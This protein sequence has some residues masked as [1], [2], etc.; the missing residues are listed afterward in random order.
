MVLAGPAPRT[1]YQPAPP[2]FAP[3][4]YFGLTSGEQAT[5]N[6]LASV[7]VPLLGTPTAT[8]TPSP[9]TST[10]LMA[11]LS[12]QTGGAIGTDNDP[13]QW[14]PEEAA[15][16]TDRALARIGTANPELAQSIAESRGKSAAEG[17]DVP[18]YKDVLKGVGDVLHA[19]HLD[20]VFELMGRTAQIVPE[21]VHDFGKQDVW[22]N[23][24]DALAGHSRISWDDVLVDNFGMKRGWLTSAIGFVGDVATDPLTYLTFGTGGLGREA[25]S[26]VVA[27]AGIEAAIKSGVVKTAEGGIRDLGPML[28]AVRAAMPGATDTELARA[29]FGLTEPGAKLAEA[30][31]SGM[32]ARVRSALH[33]VH[34]DAQPG[35]LAD[36][37]S[38]LERQGLQDVTRLGDQMFRQ[39]STGGWNRA[40]AKFAKE[41]GVDKS[42]V[43][44]ILKGYVAQGNSV[45]AGMT[46]KLAYERGK[47]AAAALGGIRFRMNIP[48]LQLRVSGARI[49]PWTSRMDF[50]MGRRFF[51]GLSGEVRLAKMVGEGE[52]PLE[53]LNAFW[54]KGWSGLRTEYRATYDKMGGH[55]SSALYTLSEGIGG[56]T[57]H[58]SPHH[59]ILRGG[60][61]PARYASQVSIQARHVA[62]QA[63]DEI[64]TTVVGDKVL[65]PKDTSER[66]VHASQ[67][68]GEYGQSGEFSDMLNEYAS[69]TPTPGTSAAVDYEARIQQLNLQ[70]RNAGEEGSPAHLAALDA[71]RKDR[72]RAVEL[73]QQIAKLSGDGDV[74]DIFRQVNHNT[75]AARLRVGQNPDVYADDIRL[76]DDLQPEDAVANSDGRAWAVDGLD[77]QA[78]INSALTDS[79][80]PGLPVRGV[81]GTLAGDVAGP[82]AVGGKVAAAEVDGV[83]RAL[84][85][86][87]VAGQKLDP[88]SLAGRLDGARL[89]GRHDYT[90]DELTKGMTPEERAQV[91]DTLNRQRAETAGALDMGTEAEAGVRQDPTAIL[92]E[93]TDSELQRSME[94]KVGI[95]SQDEVASVVQP[96]VVAAGPQR[97]LRI[98]RTA[99]VAGTPRAADE[100]IDPVAAIHDAYKPILDDIAA[101]G[102]GAA[103]AGKEALTEDQNAIL[104]EILSTTEGRDAQ[105]AAITTKL[106]KDQGYT[107]LEVKWT[108]DAGE[109]VTS[110]VSFFDDKVEAVPMSR[111]NPRAARLSN[112]GSQLR[113]VTSDLESAVGNKPHLIDEIMRRTATMPREDAEKLAQRILG[114]AGIRLK[115][116]QSVFEQ[117]AARLMELSTKR[118]AKHVA[119]YHTGKAIR[120]AENLGL[121]RGG[122]GAHAVGYDKYR[123]IVHEAGRAKLSQLSAE[124]QAASEKA[125]KF[126]AANAAELDAVAKSMGD[127]LHEAERALEAVR[128]EVNDPDLTSALQTQLTELDRTINDLAEQRIRAAGNNDRYFTTA[129]D[130]TEVEL[131]SADAAEELLMGRRL[132]KFSADVNHG[133]EQRGLPEAE[134]TGVGKH[135]WTDMG[136]GVWRKREPSSTDFE[137]LPGLGPT[138]YYYTVKD[139]TGKLRVLG[140]R[141][142]A[143]VTPDLPGEPASSLRAYVEYAYVHP[144]LRGQGV[145]TTLTMKHWGDYGVLD[146]SPRQ[147]LENMKE[148]V[149]A[150]DLSEAGAKGAKRYT[151]AA[152][153]QSKQR[154][155]K[156][157]AERVTKMKKLAEEAE[158][159][160]RYASLQ[161]IE[162]QNELNSLHARITSPRAE[163]KQALFQLEAVGDNANMAGMVPVQVPGFQ[164]YAMPAFMAQEFQRAMH[165]YPKL[166]GAHAA[167]RQF[168]SWWKTMATWLMPGFH[169]RNLEGAFFNNWLGGVDLRSYV[170]AS[171]IR[172]AEREVASGKAGKWA[173]RAIGEKDGDLVQAL[174][175][176]EPS[177]YLMGK[178]IEELTYFDLAHLGAGLNLT[179][180]NGRLF[181]EAQLTVEAEIKRFSKKANY[182]ELVERGTKPYTKAMRGAGTMTENIMR[183]AS[184][185]AEMRKGKSVWESRAMTMMRHGDYEDLTDF[186]YTW[187]RDLIPFY[188]W[189][190]TNTPFQVHQLLENPAKL[191]AVQ[192]AQR[193]VYGAQGLD[194]EKEQHRMPGWMGETGGFTIPFGVKEDQGQL[195]YDT[196]MLDL[197][198]SD[199]F[200]SGREFV[201]SFLP[202]VRPFLE[203]Y[204]FHQQTFSG[205][206]LEGKKMLMNPLFK[207]IAPFLDAMGLVERGPDGSQYMSDQT[208]NLLGIIPIYSRFKN[209]I[210]EDPKSVAK[211]SN[212]VASAVFGLGMRPIDRDALAANELNFY[213][214]QVLPQVEHL[215]QMGYPLPT[216][217]DLSATVGTTDSILQKLGITPGP[218]ES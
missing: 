27:E 53:A 79:A 116:G 125:A 6:T 128:A 112:R 86:G 52:A 217:D 181:A 175:V 44:G 78:P 22:T 51:A 15:A 23:V 88:S 134:R 214:D 201:S 212:M 202:T 141:K 174:K 102:E 167:F 152:L 7:G 132:D 98:D 151:K 162:A 177:G 114:D 50:S 154:V 169:V 10:P 56:A 20:Q 130:G 68:A 106:L 85:P 82:G 90:L 200:M 180:S 65:L 76:V 156:E 138:T 30:G 100:V 28:E 109:E 193:A 142:I 205:A 38:T 18:W 89:D 25:A 37:A 160:H 47:E 185:V 215:Q 104:S 166:D 199:M 111:I 91:W 49:I 182:L 121:L 120:S 8:G 148:A 126:D 43:D 137:E 83:I 19:T 57:K 9:N 211:R 140:Y 122:Y 73:E 32:L 189:M 80:I 195:T 179:A 178:P 173:K 145:G 60:G 99:K 206:P 48:I 196:V 14:T 95:L 16:Q 75:S 172:F 110:L 13:S 161:H 81:V 213:Y 101:G 84:E 164:Q 67:N 204:I 17:E 12:R 187:V 87:R 35:V 55:G 210:Y 186:E 41:L 194:Y 153:E 92:N 117:D 188:K 54:E 42:T 34:P 66:I 144:A 183:T 40:S 61:L 11:W 171:R 123:V 155:S 94:T 150:N 184:F 24:A 191:L 118:T 216:T 203:S 157:A 108:N 158:R 165:G 208:N 1:L 105:L 107:G 33:G 21:V 2:P 218:V 74:A 3:P 133:V 190:R 146:G 131:S 45:G 26:K 124:V 31:G 70:A 115:A 170:T 209:F 197:P 64:L 139:S 4:P 46:G 143:G 71:L 97:N 59:M 62:A 69:L 63:E 113:A 5:G 149:G 147:V 39:A 135:E 129:A 207:P 103:K 168:N 176:I 93:H 159:Q 77:S 192:K 72:D 136:D 58:L 36:M 198:M 127:K 96:R 163:A 29:I 119:N